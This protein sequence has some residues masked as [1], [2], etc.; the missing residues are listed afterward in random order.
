MPKALQINDKDNVATCL[1]AVAAGATVTVGNRQL[2]ALTD[3]PFYHKV[4]LVPLPAGAVCIKYGE[5]IGVAT[6]PIEAGE[7]VHV[8]NLESARGRGDLQNAE[9]GAR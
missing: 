6:H 9:G 2:T 3:I 8:H 4:A 5:A 7:H 1:E